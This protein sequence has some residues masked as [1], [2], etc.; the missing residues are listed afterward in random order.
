MLPD[1]HRAPPPPPQVRPSPPCIIH[2]IRHT[3]LA[4]TPHRVLTCRIR[5]LLWLWAG[6]RRPSRPSG[7]PAPWRRRTRRARGRGSISMTTT[8]AHT[9]HTTPTSSDTT[10]VRGQ[11][12]GRG[13]EGSKGP[14]PSSPR[15]KQDHPPRHIHVS[16]PILLFPCPT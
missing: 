15:L 2:C 6:R 9:T 8:T 3:Y 7:P 16:L 1:A 5:S 10:P 13:A 12:R 14:V 4:P 11:H